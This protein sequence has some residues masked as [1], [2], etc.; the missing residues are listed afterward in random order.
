MRFGGCEE[1]STRE[2]SADRRARRVVSLLFPLR[3]HALA[4]PCNQ[5]LDTPSV[6]SLTNVSANALVGRHSYMPLLFFPIY[7]SNRSQDL[8]G[9][10]EICR[11]E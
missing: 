4:S 7:S 10:S 1:G 3:H 8:L 2:T 9:S 5:H 11:N 6:V